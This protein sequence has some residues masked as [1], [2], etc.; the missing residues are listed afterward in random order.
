VASSSSWFSAFSPSQIDW[1]TLGK[2]VGLG[3]IFGFATGFAAKKAMK[4]VLIV[5]GMLLLLAVFLEQKGIITV[6]WDVLEATY[7]QS[8]NSK[9]LTETI[10]QFAQ[11]LGDLIPVSGGFVAGFL[12]GFRAG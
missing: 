1:S 6:Q 7:A 10:S 11:R 12:L 5:I 8:I 9:A 3:A 2:E 4:A